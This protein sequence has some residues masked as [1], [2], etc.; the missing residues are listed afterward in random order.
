MEAGG[1]A[2]FLHAWSYSTL[3]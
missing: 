3:I 2:C 1:G